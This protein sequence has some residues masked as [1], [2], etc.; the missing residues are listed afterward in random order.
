MTERRNTY[1]PALIWSVTISSGVCGFSRKAVTRPVESV[2]TRPKAR[3]S[4]TRVRWSETSAP[5]EEWV[6]TR[7]WMSRPVRMSPLKMRTGSSGPECSREA[8]L[9]IA[10]PVPRGSSSVTY[11]R[12]RPSAEPS[13]KCGSKTSAR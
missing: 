8:T 2:G 7:A 3:G 13:P 11:S 4:S 9:R 12:L 1:A 6:A 5:E 10:P